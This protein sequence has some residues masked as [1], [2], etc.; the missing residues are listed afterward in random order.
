MKNALPFKHNISN[1]SLPNSLTILLI[2]A[3][4]TTLF[5]IYDTLTNKNIQLIIANT[6]KKAKKL[7]DENKYNLIIIDSDEETSPE[8]YGLSKNNKNSIPI[9]II[10][11][12]TD[13]K[14][15]TSTTIKHLQKPFTKSDLKD[16]IKVL[17]NTHHLH[18]SYSYNID[19]LN[20]NNLLKI[21]TDKSLITS[22]LN[23]MLESFKSEI[24]EISDALNEGS[25]YKLKKI[26]HKI[27]PNFHLI[28]LGNIQRM[29]ALIENSNDRETIQKLANEI[30]KILPKVR[31]D[32]KTILNNYE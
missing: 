27:K 21:S 23:L 11:Q 10:N 14:T 22:T 2:E 25:S 5:K 28:G 4:P 12:Q 1:Y 13:V 19:N 30:K 32:I 26:A 3:T 6:R 16:N 9:L 15:I 7:I 24:S 18:S 17:L 8:Q 29:C 20:I 31:K